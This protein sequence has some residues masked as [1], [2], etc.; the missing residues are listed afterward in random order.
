[1]RGCGNTLKLLEVP[2]AQEYRGSCES[3]CVSRW[4]RGHWMVT[5]SWDTGTWVTSSKVLLEESFILYFLMDDVHRLNGSGS[6]MC[7]GSL[8]LLLHDRNTKTINIKG[9]NARETIFSGGRTYKK[10]ETQ[11]KKAHRI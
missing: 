1:M 6:G 10:E 8:R 11:A 7:K 2:N 9:K 5:T 4:C 3:D